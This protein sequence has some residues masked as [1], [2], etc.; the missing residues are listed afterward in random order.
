MKIDQCKINVFIRSLKN[1][2][3]TTQQKKTLRGQAFAGDLAGAISGLE[4]LTKQQRHVEGRMEI[5]W[6]KE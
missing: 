5:K 3:L 6:A 1:Y 4:R 2:P